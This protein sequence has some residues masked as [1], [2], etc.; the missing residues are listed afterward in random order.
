MF[1]RLKYYFKKRKCSFKE[2]R[3]I[4]NPKKTIYYVIRRPSP[5]AGFFSNYFY[6]LSHII[7]ANQNGWQSVVDME[8]YDTLYSEKS[9]ICGTKNAWEYYFNQP[10]N[11]S[12]KK[13][14]SSHN[15]ILS[16]D[17]YRGEMGVPVYEINQGHITKEMVDSLYPLQAK[18]CPVR[19]CILEEVDCF[20]KKYMSAK[21]FIGVHI[22]GTDMKIPLSGHTIPPK[23]S[24]VIEQIDKILTSVDAGI[25]LCCD[26]K[27]TVDLFID[28]Y[29]ERVIYTSSYRASTGTDVGI[30]MQISDRDNHRYLLGKEVLEDSLLLSKCDYLICGISNVTSAAVLFNNNQYKEVFLLK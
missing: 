6:V 15:Y 1:N 12:L 17:R 29:R 16:D 9:K 14:Y 11:I 22:R 23:I 19:D 30:H 21:T 8:K 20:Y 24:R 10:T 18:Y 26:E 13:A 4:H 3:V 2:K 25:F 5:G 7:Y 27:S 28:K